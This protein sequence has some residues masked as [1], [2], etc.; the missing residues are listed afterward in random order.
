MEMIRVSSMYI[1][2][3]LAGKR[4]YALFKKLF[5][6]KKRRVWDKDRIS[7]LFQLI[8]KTVTATH[9]YICEDTKHIENDYLF[10]KQKFLFQ[11]LIELREF[12]MITFFEKD[13]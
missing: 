5:F 6:R 4:F 11:I 2:Q 9:A 10:S 1:I 8:N 13:K 12:D 3:P 7:L